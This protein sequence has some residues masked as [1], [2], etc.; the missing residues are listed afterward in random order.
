VWTEERP[1]EWLITSSA[2]GGMMQPAAWLTPRSTID[3]AGPW[4]EELTLHDDG[5]FFA[6]VLLES[7]RN[8]FVRDALVY[9]R[10]VK[11]SLSRTRGNTASESA[12]AVCSAKA[13]MLL[14]VR[15]DEATRRAAA[16]EFAR[17]IYEFQPSAPELAENALQEMRKL[18]VEPAPAVGGGIFRGLAAILGF[19]R[20]LRIRSSLSGS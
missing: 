5:E 13:K 15:D 1:I 19:E 9:Y 14:G 18:G 12:F 17:F 8:V 4:N 16:T 11:G 6:R 20:A 7:E 2:G 3:K 10:T